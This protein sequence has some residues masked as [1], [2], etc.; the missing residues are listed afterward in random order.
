MLARWGIRVLPLLYIAYPDNNL[1]C[2]ISF[3]LM[4]CSHMLCKRVQHSTENVVTLFLNCMLLHHI[5][6]VIDFAFWFIPLEI[7]V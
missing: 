2:S 6:K 3:F 7:V 5:S 4:L 1:S